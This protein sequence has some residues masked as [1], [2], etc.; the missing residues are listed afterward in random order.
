GRAARLLLR[1]DGAGG[2][3][4]HHG[5]HARG[6]VR[7]A[8]RSRARRLG[9]R[10]RRAHERYAV[11]PHRR[12]LHR[13]PRPCRARPGA[14]EHRHGLLELLRPS[15]PAPAVD[16]TRRLGPRRHP[17]ARRDRRLRA[18]EGLAPARGLNR[19]KLAGEALAAA[20]RVVECGSVDG[21][22]RAMTVVSEQLAGRP[23][24]DA[25][26]RG[27]AQPSTRDTVAGPF[28]L[29]LPLLFAVL[30]C[31]HLLAGATTQLTINAMRSL[32][33]FAQESRAFEWRVLPYWRL[34]AYVAG[35]VAVFTYLWPVVLHF[36]RPVEPVPTRVQ[37]RVLSAPFLVAA[38][39]FAPW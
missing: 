16:G 8:D 11:R 6:D 21:R 35:T 13:R 34:T 10:G 33:P 28:P 30:L 26:G 37:R 25:V 7:P 3:R 2:R 36:R 18:A 31:V 20:P 39:T 19:R 12:R 38:M 23:A 24:Q 1:A 27:D 29:W 9:R 4:P 5:R 15:E 17:L 22:G 32:S 14:R